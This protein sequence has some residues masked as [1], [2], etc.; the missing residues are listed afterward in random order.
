LEKTSGARSTFWTETAPSPAGRRLTQSLD[1]DVCVVG[2]GISGLTTAYLLAKAGKTVVVLEDGEIGSGETGR[3]TAHL[4][5]ALDDRYEEIARLHGEE[6]AR[7]AA[8]SH[9]QAISQIEIIVNMEQIACDFER[10]PGYLFLGPDDDPAIL[11]GEYDAA[12]RAGLRGVQ[13]MVRAPLASFDTGPCL[14]FPD[15]GQF[16][17]MKYLAGLAR[18]IAGRRGQIFTGAHA[19]EIEGGD[20][21]RITT[22]DG[23]VVTAGAVVVATNTPVND[24]VTMHTKQAAYRT[25]VVGL[26]IDTGAVPRALYWDTPH[27]YHYVRVAAEV[28]GAE[29]LIVGGEDHKTG[30]AHDTDERFARL[31]TWT[32]ERFPV[33]GASTYRWSGQVMEPV[34]GMA[35]IGANPGDAKNVFIVTG[36]SGNGMTHGTIAGILLTD[37]ILGR[38]NPWAALY[39]PARVT[40]RAA[41]QFLKENLN[42]AAQYGDLVTAG[43]LESADQLR[44]GEG[45]II[46]RGVKKI[47][48]FRDV[49]G[50]LH[51]FSAACPHLGC[52]V[53]WNGTEKTW[54][55]PCHGSRFDAQGSVLNGPAITGLRRTD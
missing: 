24:L 23:V 4:V 3:T 51:E 27:P 26:P 11:D 15:Q 21:A 53:Q 50:T 46:R 38:K 28:S 36:D 45:A 55:C 52:I 43:D 7:L 54:D 49:R 17:P 6:G 42:V 9:T 12:Q 48:A 19:A 44:A 8:D 22:A 10:L 32:R 34:D 29:V 1:A 16:H 41:G 20:R 5:N 30:Q 40:L 37:L 47:A 13:K 2:A 18:A 31:E 25:Y 33:R 35:F 39:D 14:H